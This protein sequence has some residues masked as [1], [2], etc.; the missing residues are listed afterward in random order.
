MESDEVCL[1]NPNDY[2]SIQFPDFS[3]KFC[4]RIIDRKLEHIVDDVVYER[5]YDWLIKK[6]PDA[7]LRM[8]TYISSYTKFYEREY[9]RRKVELELEQYQAKLKKKVNLVHNP[10]NDMRR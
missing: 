4:S 9:P 2:F 1:I 8:D 6:D 3:L 10:Y 5:W 7:V